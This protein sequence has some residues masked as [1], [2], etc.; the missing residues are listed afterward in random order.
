MIRIEHLTKGFKDKIVISNMNFE[1]HNGSIFGL[2]GING[3]GKSTLLRLISGVLVP[4]SGHVLID[5]VNV[6]NNPS[7]KK[8][9]FFLSD[10]PTYANFSTLLDLKKLYEVFY[11]FDNNIFNQIVNTFEINTNTPLKNL[12]KGLRRQAYIALGFSVNAK[13]LLFD[14]VFDGLDPKARLKFKQMLIDYY[15]ADKIIIMTSHSLR[16]LEDICDSFG[17]ID[18]GTFIKHGQIDS[19]IGKYKKYQVILKDTNPIILDDKSILYKQ[20]GRVLTVILDFK[21][22][23]KDIIDESLILVVDDMPIS[24]EEYFI[25]S[26]EGGLSWKN[27]C[28]IYL[29][30]RF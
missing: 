23:L 9:L 8:E 25:I 30:K 16:E 20:D 29:K 3:S 5:G 18:S 2:I 13:Y 28:I 27:I 12:S 22:A 6:I 11:T 14:E 17:M 24:F 15:D 21:V 26:E 4:E 1:F 7:I 19:E 10:D